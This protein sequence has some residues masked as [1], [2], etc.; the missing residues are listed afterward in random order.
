[1]NT[2]VSARNNFMTTGVKIIIKNNNRRTK[3]QA[4]KQK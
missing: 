4:T 2:L 3:K 1:M